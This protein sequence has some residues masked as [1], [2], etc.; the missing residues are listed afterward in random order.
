MSQ[1]EY[2]IRPISMDE[3]LP[4]RCLGGGRAMPVPAG[5]EPGCTSLCD[6]YTHGSR[7]KL[8]AL[9]AEVLSNYGGCGFVAWEGDKIIAYH[10]FFPHEIARRVRFYGWGGSE[11]DRPHTLVHNCIT[12]VRGPYHR[13]GIASNLIR[14]SLAW[15]GDNGWKR[16]EVH[17]VRPDHVEFWGGEQKSCVAFWEKLGFRIFDCEPDLGV[18][19][20]MARDVGL[21]FETEQD[22]DRLMPEWRDKC[23]LSSMVADL[24]TWSA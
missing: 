6:F 23:V 13:K 14:H 20:V 4:D 16:F 15:G 22:A 17:L 2:E 10:N 8:V 19:R 9:Y 3:W 24:D 21:T 7:E 1:L 12:L 11:E 5:A 18:A